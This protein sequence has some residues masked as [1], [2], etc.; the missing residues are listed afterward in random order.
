MNSYI[1]FCEIAVMVLAGCGAIWVGERVGGLVTWLQ[2]RHREV[3]D[4]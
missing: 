1:E 3:G 4:E 2:G